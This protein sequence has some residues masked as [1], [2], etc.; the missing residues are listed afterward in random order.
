MT[1]IKV[2]VGRFVQMYWCTPANTLTRIVISIFLALLFGLVFVTAE[3]NSHSGLNSGVGVVFIAA[4]FNSMVCVLPLA[5]YRERAGQ[6]Y[7][8]FWYFL[9]LTLAEIPYCLASLLVFTV[10]FFPMVGFTGFVMGVLFWINMAVL[11]LMHVPGPYAFPSE[12][13]AVICGVLVNSVFLLFMGFSPPAYTIPGG[14]QWLYKIVPQRFSLGVLVSL[15]A[16]SRPPTESYLN[17]GSQL[18][19]Q[20]MQDSPVTVGHITRKEYTEEYFGK[21]R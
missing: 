9:G 5:F 6:T 15:T 1:Q 10:M 14:Y 11:I 7:N 4:L 2:V 18:G 21:A 13:V 17:V 19:C 12:E 16:T 8:A 20:P 3:Y